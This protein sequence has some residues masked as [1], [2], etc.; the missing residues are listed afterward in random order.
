MFSYFQNSG[1]AQQTTLPLRGGNFSLDSN[2]LSHQL[3]KLLEPLARDQMPATAST[4]A[5]PDDRWQLKLQSDTIGGWTKFDLYSSSTS[6]ALPISIP[7]SRTTVHAWF[8]DSSGALVTAF[9]GA[10]PRS[11]SEQGP[12]RLFF[13]DAKNQFIE[14][15]ALPYPRDARLA[16]TVNSERSEALVT[17]REGFH[18]MRSFFTVDLFQSKRIT[19]SP[20]RC[21]PTFRALAP[22]KQG[23]LGICDGREG[24]G[25][26]VY[27]RA[28]RDPITIAAEQKGI[29]R[30]AAA[31]GQ[32]FLLVYYSNGRHEIVK[33]NG[34]DSD[35][36]ETIYNGDLVVEDIR[37]TRNHRAIATVSR[38]DIAPFEVPCN[39]S[40]MANASFILSRLPYSHEHRQFTARDG[41]PIPVEIVHAHGRQHANL[42]ICVY[43]TWG[44]IL[45]A[46]FNALRSSWLELGGSVAWI[47]VRGGGEYGARWHIAGQGRAKQVSTDD[48]IDAL[49]GMGADTSLKGYNFIGAG[50]S[51]GATIIA[52]ALALD[53]NCLK[54]AVLESGVYD[55]ENFPAYSLGGAWRNE[56]GDPQSE[57]AIF[58]K[59]TPLS[60]ARQEQAPPL[61]IVGG[62]KDETVASAHSTRLSLMMAGAGNFAGSRLD[63]APDLGHDLDLPLT[64]EA[65]SPERRQRI[66]MLS[67]ELEFL[68]SI[69]Q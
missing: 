67:K 11:S 12:E 31:V 59:R 39:K 1:I 20:L 2:A 34:A 13:I 5:S 32:S 29:L 21:D 55:M 48:F 66:D 36:V 51:A 38:L 17:M 64:F 42:L 61:L 22:W 25:E 63:L 14:E 54:G 45:D 23:Y 4:S 58:S 60:L 49:K 10:S 41:T 56:F 52:S 15:I 24:R 50:Y 53:P 27:V 69:G 35:A 26:L 3:D 7:Y 8:K 16:L 9:P 44:T 47:G 30:T 18:K 33:K 40:D 37:V 6:E 28:G 62:R 65:N 57:S 19:F 46:R 68:L 43:G